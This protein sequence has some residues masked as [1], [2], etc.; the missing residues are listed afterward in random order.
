MPI[1]ENKAIV[2]R[3]WEEVWNQK[4]LTVCDEIFDEAYATHEK[5]WAAYVFGVI[6]DIHFNVEDMIAEDDKVV[7][8]FIV[9]GTHQ[10]EF[11]GAPGTG[12]T[13]SVTGMWIHRLENGRIVE[14]RDW[15]EWDALGFL[16]QVG[17]VPT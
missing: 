12:K 9:S 10:G 14:G 7:T 4:I 3:L 15:G 6:A 1:K 11:L 13:F 16:Q 17:A 5:G 2:R 8:R